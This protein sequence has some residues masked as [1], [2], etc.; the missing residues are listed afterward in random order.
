MLERD[1]GDEGW[2]EDGMEGDRMEWDGGR[3]WDGW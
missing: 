2:V 3:G 1:E